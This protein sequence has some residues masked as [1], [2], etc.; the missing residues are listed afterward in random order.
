MCERPPSGP[1]AA[2]DSCALPGWHVTVS[3]L[4]MTYVAK[5]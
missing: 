3:L 5:G 4:N 1:V 2:T